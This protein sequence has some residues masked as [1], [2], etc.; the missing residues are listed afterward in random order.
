MEKETAPP[1]PSDVQKLVDALIARLPRLEPAVDGLVRTFD[2]LRRNFEAGGVLYLCGN[3]GSFADVVHIKAEL[4]KSFEGDRPIASPEVRGRLESGE[5]GRVLLRELEG[6][7]PV[8]VLGESDGLRSA[9]ENDREPVYC[10]A[11][12]L[13]SFLGTLKRG[14]LMGVS[15][16]GTARNVLAAA[17]LAQ[18]YG[19]PVIGFTGPDGGP[20]AR[21][22]D[23]AWKAP[24]GSTAEIQ[25]HQLPLYHTLCRMLERQFFK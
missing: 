6:G 15:T 5:L 19:L 20:L 3:G 11:Q 16:S 25:E 14:T 18:A 1:L 12:E 7:L 2:C 22:A 23:V 8:V 13:N 17:T 21:M 4:A 10:Y 24:G 9:Y